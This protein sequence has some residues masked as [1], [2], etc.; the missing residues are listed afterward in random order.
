VA[1]SARKGQ[2]RVEHQNSDRETPAEWN[3]EME[4]IMVD[5]DKMTA[6]TEMTATEKITK[7]TEKTTEETERT[8]EKTEEMDAETENKIEE[9]DVEMENKIEETDTETENVMDETTMEKIKEDTE[10]ESTAD[11][12]Q[13]RRNTRQTDSET[14]LYML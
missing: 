12:Y 1:W 4:N 13:N 5:T 8:T 11:S 10:V 6:T 2:R 9:T 7:E 14:I 3:P